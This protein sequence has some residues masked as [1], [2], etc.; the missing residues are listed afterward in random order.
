MVVAEPAALLVESDDEQVLA[1]QLLEH[2][3]RVVTFQHRVAERSAHRLEHGCPEQELEL[4]RLDAAELLGSQ[5]V[6]H[7]AVV[8]AERRD[9]R[10]AA[11]Q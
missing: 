4:C 5:V 9:R 8:A 1:L 10:A 6:R 7:E 2:P 3:S 11:V